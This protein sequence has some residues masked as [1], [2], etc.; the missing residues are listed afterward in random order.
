VNAN[1]AESSHLSI[2]ASS[3]TEEYEGQPVI[4][5]GSAEAE[6]IEG[7]FDVGGEE[8]LENKRIVLN[9]ESELIV[10]FKDAMKSGYGRLAISL[11]L[12]QG[13]QIKTLIVPLVADDIDDA[14]GVTTFKLGDAIVSEEVVI[15]NNLTT[16]DQFRVNRLRVVAVAGR[17]DVFTFPPLA[18]TEPGETGSVEAAIDS[19][20][21]KN[22]LVE[23]PE[24]EE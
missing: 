24:S 9:S 2:E 10:T 4:R 18:V 5:S 1:G 11:E 15:L 3:Y 16:I 21:F 12:V 19:I 6:Y 7:E 13:T 14:D 23:E 20:L 17:D 22:V 8:P